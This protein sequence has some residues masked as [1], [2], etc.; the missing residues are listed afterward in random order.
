[1]THLFSTLARSRWLAALLLC[2]ALT[3][4]GGDSADNPTGTPGGST[5]TPTGGN[6]PN[7]PPA[8]KPSIR[9]AP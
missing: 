4:C 6:E 5:E 3:A 1:M 2:A 7:Q 8:V 9:C